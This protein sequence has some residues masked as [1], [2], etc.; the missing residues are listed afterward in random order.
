MRRKRGIVD[1]QLNWIFVLVVGALIVAF[2]VF[3]V[4]KQRLLAKDSLD[5]DIKIKLQSILTTAQQSTST[6]YPITIPDIEIRFDC[7]GFRIGNLE[8]IRMKGAFAPELLKSKKN[9]IYVSSEEFSMPFKA[10]NLLL[11]TAP[12]VRY[13]FYEGNPKNPDVGRLFS[14]PKNPSMP[15]NITKELVSDCNSLN[16]KSNY[17][18]RFVL[19]NEDPVTINDCGKK[20]KKGEITAVNIIP[21]AGGLSGRGTIK[22]YEWNGKSFSE[23]ST[24]Y[25]IGTSTILGA[26]FSDSK[27]AY[28]CGLDAA[29]DRLRIIANITYE[30]AEDFKDK[31]HGT[32]C[33]NYFTDNLVINEM[34]VGLGNNDLE[35]R[36]EST[37]AMA[38]KIRNYNK[39]LSTK[40]CPLLY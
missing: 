33:G 25:Y 19:V 30:R 38:V 36:V 14:D 15:D 16:D 27:E 22:F 4:Q 5:A 1:V 24:S 31:S 2:F 7:E 35:Q 28:E 21:V 11:I 32:D 12:D 40:S 20:I 18:V 17:K 39:L 29:L 34:I 13:V 8:P 3:V 23:K 26:V 6:Q 37:Y 9:M 10:V